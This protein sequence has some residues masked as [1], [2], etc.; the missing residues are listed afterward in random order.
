M[1]TRRAVVALA[2]GAA[3]LLSGCSAV[4]TGRGQIAA[5]AASRFPSSVP[6]STAP[7]SGTSRPVGTPNEPSARA[8]ARYPRKSVDTAIGDPGTADLCQIV[9]TG[10]LTG[11]GGLVAERGSAQYLPECYIDLAGERAGPTEL[12]LNVYPTRSGPQQAAGRT[13]TRVAGLRV[14]RLPYLAKYGSCERDVVARGVTIRVD[15]YRAGG[16]KPSQSVT[17]K[18][19]TVMSDGIAAAVAAHHVPRLFEPYPGLLSLNACATARGAQLTR[20]PILQGARFEDD[21]FGVTCRLVTPSLS[22]VVQPILA[23]QEVPGQTSGKTIGG[24]QVYESA[25]DDGYRHC[26]FYSVLGETPTQSWEQLS[27]EAYALTTSVS[28]LCGQAGRALGLYLD[29]AGL[30]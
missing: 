23:D 15:T 13:S 11:I 16:A 1:T 10:K 22:L 24:H 20:L 29:T 2:C 17:C 5:P 9:D 25:N 12:A 18:V 3:V 28:D 30:R 27:V 21:E 6:T 26:S 7:S 14:Y 19:T 8:R 4:V